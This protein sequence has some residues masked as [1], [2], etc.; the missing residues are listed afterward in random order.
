MVSGSEV[1]MAY[2]KEAFY[3]EKRDYEIN[4]TTKLNTWVATSPKLPNWNATHGGPVYLSV[5]ENIIINTTYFNATAFND[6]DNTTSATY[7]VNTTIY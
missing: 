6:D 5:G 2:R 7:Y 3:I 4:D 1:L